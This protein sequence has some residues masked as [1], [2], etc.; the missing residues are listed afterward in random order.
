MSKLKKITIKTIGGNTFELQH[1]I[2]IKSQLLREEMEKSTSTTLTIELDIDSHTIEQ[3]VAFLVYHGNMND[4][5]DWDRKFI[6]QI[7]GNELINL[8][9]AAD[10]L[11][12]QRLILLAK[13]KFSKCFDNSDLDEIRSI[14]NVN[15]TPEE[16][17]FL[18]NEI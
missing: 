3:V 13:N 8:A 12:I 18:N 2:A 6:D 1:G 16:L 17:E 14:F 9:W 15:M 11:K 10:Y 4:T 7:S 5:T